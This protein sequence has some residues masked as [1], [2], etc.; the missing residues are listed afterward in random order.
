MSEKSVCKHCGAAITHAYGALW[1]DGSPV[2]PQYC[3][4][5]P[6]GFSRLHEP[7]LEH[8]QVSAPCPSNTP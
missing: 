2:F 6:S 3:V 4:V 7:S 1:H 5:D 8:A